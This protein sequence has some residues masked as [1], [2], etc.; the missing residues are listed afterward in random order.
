MRANQIAG[1]PSDFKMNIIK[2]GIKKTASNA[3][4]TRMRPDGKSI[5]G[6]MSG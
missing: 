2:F 5:F 1:I 6:A 4:I 3:F